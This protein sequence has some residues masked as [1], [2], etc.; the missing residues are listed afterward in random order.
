MLKIPVLRAVLWL[1]IVFICLLVVLPSIYLVLWA[2]AGTETVGVLSPHMS[3]Q[4]F[5]RILSDRD[6]QISLAYSICLAAGASG[7]GCTVLLFHFYFMRFSTPFFD[8]LSY[9]S[10]LV[11]VL[12]PAVAYALALRIVG[13]LL[14]V[15]ETELLAAGHLVLVLPLQFF[16]LESKQEAVNTNLLFAASTLGASHL[17]SI[18]FVYFP[19]MSEALWG[20][21]IVGFFLSFDELVIATFVIDSSF[22]T[23]PKKLWD[24]VNRSMDPSPAVI[25]CLAAGAYLTTVILVFVLQKLRRFRRAHMR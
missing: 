19:L 1:L 5:R 14:H 12:M 23:V 25:S 18:R 21:F 3:L 17:R 24:Q 13:G 8:R 9:V 4:W 22:A 10:V 15:P 7:V 20:A 6:W 2:F 16:V 11:V